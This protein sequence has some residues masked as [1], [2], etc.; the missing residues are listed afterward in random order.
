MMASYLEYTNI[1]DNGVQDDEHA[2]ELANFMLDILSKAANLWESDCRN[3]NSI[4]SLI[5]AVDRVV[6]FLRAASEVV[7]ADQDQWVSLSDVF[8]DLL[9]ILNERERNLST[10]A[11]TTTRMQCSVLR[12]TG[13]PGRPP[14]NI[15]A[16][17]VEDLRGYGFSWQKISEV[18]GVSR[19]TLRRR[20]S[21]KNL[22]NQ[23]EF[24]LISDDELDA[25]IREYFNSHGTSGQTYV[26]GYLRSLGTHIQRQRIRDCM[27]RLNPD[28]QF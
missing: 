3:V 6:S 15:P 2:Q 17:M 18:L 7:D 28:M 8:S 10:R 26:S 9:A 21:E 25:L 12:H 24:S 5:T 14:L 27:T 22:P 13:E 16:E 19:W 20:V 1:A 4:L 23:R 11:T